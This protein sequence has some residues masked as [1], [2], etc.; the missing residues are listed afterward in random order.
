MEQLEAFTSSKNQ[1]WETPN[2]LFKQLNDEFNFT[3][4]VCAL[5]ETSKCERYY[6]PT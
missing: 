6:T 5:P 4:D 3:I 1:E 2:E